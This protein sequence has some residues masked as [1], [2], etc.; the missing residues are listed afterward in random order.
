MP[1]G[2]ERARLGF[3]VADDAGNREAGIVESGTEGMD[4][5]VAEF[6]SLVD[7][8]GRL[9]GDVA[10]HAA[11]ERELPEE[12]LQSFFILRDLRID[13]AVRALE[14]GV[15]DHC[16]SAVTGA[17]DVEDVCAAFPDDPIQM[18]VDEIQARRRTPVTEQPGLHVFRLQRLAQQGIV[19]EI[20]LAD[21]HVVSRA[22]VAVHQTQLRVIQFRHPDLRI[23]MPATNRSPVASPAGHDWPVAASAATNTQCNSPRSPT[24]AR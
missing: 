6:A 1:G 14:V 7:R 17:A 20:Y 10:G 3:P 12:L 4:K 8:T 13:L 18:H 11:R 15:G 9:W 5:G 22:P 19:H 16:R 21:R 23:Q 2:R 24:L